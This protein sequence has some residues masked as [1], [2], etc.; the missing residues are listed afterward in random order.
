VNSYGKGDLL[1]NI[2]VWIPKNLSRE[3]KKILEKLDESDNFKPAP[4]KREKGFFHRMKDY[5]E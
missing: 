2:N 1:V 3:E 4:N 5:F